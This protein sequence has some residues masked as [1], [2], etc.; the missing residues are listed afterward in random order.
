MGVVMGVMIIIMAVGF[1]GFGH[2]HNMMGGHGKEEQKN[3]STIHDHNKEA[4]CPDC[5]QEPEK[6]NAD[7]ESKTNDQ[8][9]I[10][11]GN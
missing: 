7:D 1:L 6:K 4:P 11:E 5:P 9:K 8:N 2:H 10:Q 3:E